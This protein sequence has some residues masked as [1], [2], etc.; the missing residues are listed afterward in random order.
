MIPKSS[1][2]IS[3]SKVTLGNPSTANLNRLID[4]SWRFIPDLNPRA[5]GPDTQTGGWASNSA[6]KV[7]RLY[8][9]RKA[10][11]IDMGGLFVDVESFVKGLKMR[12]RSQSSASA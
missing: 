6:I 2:L 1:N 3:D 9:P 11:R 4:L 7:P 5:F 10:R 12:F 8:E